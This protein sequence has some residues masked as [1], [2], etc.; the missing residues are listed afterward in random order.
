IWQETCS[1]STK[2]ARLEDELTRIEDRLAAP[3]VYGDEKILTRTLLRQD[4]LLQ[5]YDRLE[6]PRY[7][8]Y[9]RSTLFSLGFN[10]SDLNLPVETLSGGQKKLV[11]LAKLLVTKPDMLLLDEP[12]NH[13]DLDGKRFLERF[14]REY[15]GGVIIVSH[16][17][18]LLDLVADEIAELEDGKLVLYPGNYSEYAFEKETRLLRQQQLFQAQH[19]EITRL[20]QSAKRLL[21]WG[22]VYDNEKFIRRGQSILKR[23]E[24]IERIDKPILDRRQM[25]LELGGRR[26]GDKVLEIKGLT[27]QFAP[28]GD[29]GDATTILADVNL[30]VIR[31][32]RV[33]LVG[34]NGAGKSLLFRIILEQEPPSA[35]QI[36]IGPS[37]K[38]G[39]YAQQHETLDYNR[40]LIETVRHAARFTEE[41]AVGFL[42]RFL[43]DYDQA[44]GPVEN[45]SGGERSRLQMALLMLSGANFLMLDEPT[46]N[47][48]IASI[49]VLENVLEEFDGTVLTISHDRYFLD[50]VADRIS[51]LDGGSITEYPGS[52]SDYNAAKARSMS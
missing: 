43:F 32:Q 48:D 26:G 47:L 10:E 44:R 33:G 20:E 41:A 49:E 8:G 15:K 11:G 14:I 31:G 42:R 12:D 39:Y 51:E 4:K 35:G 13:L 7:E 36:E 1:A 16:D 9:V 52:Y 50:R 3:E 46:N 17:R 6:G 40:T 27:K 34:P 30:L 24:K 38:T 28:P 21:T 45:L 22:K 19:K 29:G 25:G 5:E 37:I 2:L 23:L 18:Y